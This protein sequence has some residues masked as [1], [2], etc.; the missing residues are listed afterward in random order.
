[1][2]LLHNEKG[3]ETKKKRQDKVEALQ[4]VLLRVVLPFPKYQLL[5]FPLNGS[6][7]E[8]VDDDC[9]AAASAAAPPI[10]AC[11]VSWTDYLEGM[12]LFSCH[13]GERTRQR[14]SPLK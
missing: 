6:K 8:S 11:C 13:C 7:D 1:M 2:L 4:R 9:C 14:M 5:L 3:K 12:L 10:S